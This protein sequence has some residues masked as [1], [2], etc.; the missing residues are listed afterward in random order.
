MVRLVWVTSAQLF[1]FQLSGEVVV[2]IFDTVEM[3]FIASTNDPDGSSSDARNPHG[4]RANPTQPDL[5]NM[6]KQVSSFIRRRARPVQRLQDEFCTIDGHSSVLVPA[7]RSLL[8]IYN[9]D[10]IHSKVASSRVLGGPRGPEL[11]AAYNFSDGSEHEQ[12]LL[13][14]AWK[15]R[16]GLDIQQPDLIGD[17]EALS[18]MLGR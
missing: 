7:N 17:G 4:Q 8:V 1:G 6:N 13:T 2:Y 14:S 15:L 12:T 10:R 9:V 16:R 5:A 11:S 3:L 18:T